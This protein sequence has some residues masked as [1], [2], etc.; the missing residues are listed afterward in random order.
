L[1]CGCK[2]GCR[3]SI[4]QVNSGL[5]TEDIPSFDYGGCVVGDKA[6]VATLYCKANGV[7]AGVP[8]FTK[9]FEQLGCSVEWQVKVGVCANQHGLNDQVPALGGNVH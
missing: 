3:T 1:I 7:V 4:L 6:E 2:V 9:V 8:F 5:F